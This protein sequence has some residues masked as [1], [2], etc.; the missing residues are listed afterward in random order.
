MYV[1]WGMQL[2]GVI[3]YMDD[4][5]LERA[6]S[7][8][9]SLV[10][11][12]GINQIYTWFYEVIKDPHIPYDQLINSRSFRSGHYLLQGWNKRKWQI[13]TIGLGGV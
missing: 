11:P 2:L 5:R 9:Q 1:E 6:F 12:G 8:V 13:Y 10:P 4:S 7:G 3:S